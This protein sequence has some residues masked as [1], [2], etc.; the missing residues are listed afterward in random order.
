[1]ILFTWEMY[2]IQEVRQLKWKRER[3][4]C[5]LFTFNIPIFFV[6]KNT[7]FFIIHVKIRVSECESDTLEHFQ[8]FF[9]LKRND[10]FDKIYFRR[11]NCL[12]NHTSL[13]QFWARST[14]FTKLWHKIS[15]IV[16]L[17]SF[18]SEFFFCSTFSV[19]FNC[20]DNRSSLTGI[21]GNYGVILICVKWFNT[22]FC[23][24]IRESVRVVN[25]LANRRY[26]ICWFFLSPKKKSIRTQQD[27]ASNKS[28]FEKQWNHF[29][30]NPIG[31]YIIG[32]EMFF[33]SVLI[34]ISYHWILIL[35]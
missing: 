22:Q 15:R 20:L 25:L 28:W 12:W 18:L 6:H 17:H 24:D 9:S 19:H 14:P 4:R 30:M 5:S 10:D 29:E 35:N 23:L 2:H 34:A 31:R 16:D 8:R 11:K 7:V 13:G 33:S 3:E 26:N 1:M 21:S 27:T 32:F